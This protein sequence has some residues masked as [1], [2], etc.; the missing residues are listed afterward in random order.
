MAEGLHWNVRNYSWK[1]LLTANDVG[2]FP[3]SGPIC[4]FQVKAVCETKKGLHISVSAAHCENPQPDM[5]G[6]S[7]EIPNTK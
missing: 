3:V 4:C 1:K 6:F 2:S 7:K 5:N